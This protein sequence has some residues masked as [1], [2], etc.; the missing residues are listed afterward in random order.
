MD[1]SEGLVAYIHVDG[2]DRQ[3]IISVK[4]MSIISTPLHFGI[5]FRFRWTCGGITKHPDGTI[6]SIE[7]LRSLSLH[8]QLLCRSGVR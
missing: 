6:P 1:F 8:G 7:Y 4:I 2:R 5:S 3:A